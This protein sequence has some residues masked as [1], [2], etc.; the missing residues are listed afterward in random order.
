MVVG[1]KNI[2]IKPVVEGEKSFKESEPKT[3]RSLH[4]S[5]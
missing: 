4:F 2:K 5:L 1:L 3:N